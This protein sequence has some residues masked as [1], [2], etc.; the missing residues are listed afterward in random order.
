[1]DSPDINGFNDRFDVEVLMAQLSHI[2]AGLHGKKTYF[3]VFFHT[4]AESPRGHV[5][6]DN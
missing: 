5:I 6:V 3:Y 2:R 1:M 4:L